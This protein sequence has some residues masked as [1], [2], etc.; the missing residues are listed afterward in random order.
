MNYWIGTVTQGGNDAYAV[1]SFATALLGQ[2]NQAGL[3]RE[4]IL[5]FPT[6]TAF[7]LGA[8]TNYELAV[9]RYTKAAMPLT[10]DNDVIIKRK[11]SANMTT[12]GAIAAD[13]VQRYTYSEDD[14][15]L[16]VED[17]LYLCIDSNNTGAANTGIC[18]IG[19][20]LERISQDQ[21]LALLQLGLS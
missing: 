21:R 15:L 13:M 19:Y 11:V 20:T 6:G 1:A 7:V 16:V 3:I 2:T 17:P 12:S 8:L 5:E 4:I 10:S 14:E 18:R 9:S